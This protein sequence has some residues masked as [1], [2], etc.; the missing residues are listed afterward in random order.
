MPGLG[1]VSL[2]KIQLRAALD[3]WVSQAR[4]YALSRDIT[5][6]QVERYGLGY[7]VFG[8]MAGRIILPSRDVEGRPRNYTAR[9]FNGH[10]K[11]YLAADMRERPDT[12]T[13]FGEQFW[14]PP[15]TRRRVVALE[16][17]ING[18]AVERA[19]PELPFAVIDGS[20]PRPAHFAKLATFP[21]V[22][23][24]TDSDKAGDKASEILEC[25]LGRHVLV[26]RARF[27]AG[28]D[29]QKA[30]DELVREVLWQ[31]EK[32]RTSAS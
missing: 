12:G 19:C 31:G 8:N 11:R 23:I 1:L 32:Q 4:D 16:G 6:E 2:R 26:T 17:A 10:H 22:I 24:L 20:E 29:A 18:L 27:P 25:G 21:H 9:A 28:I 14:P 15:T 13:M 5:P 7:A 30:G 3:E